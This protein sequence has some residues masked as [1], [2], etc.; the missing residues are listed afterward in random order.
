MHSR[1]IKKDTVGMSNLFTTFYVFQTKATE[2][3]GVV[4]LLS[5]FYVWLF[6]RREYGGESTF[7]SKYEGFA[8]FPQKYVKFFWFFQDKKESQHFEISRSGK[9]ILRP[10]VLSFKGI[11]C[12]SMLLS[13]PLKV[14]SLPSTPFGWSFVEQGP[15]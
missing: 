2:G 6:H 13:L 3:S 9:Y 15:S 12:F 5:F 11:D 1:C 10:T 8:S 7:F 4:S 14:L